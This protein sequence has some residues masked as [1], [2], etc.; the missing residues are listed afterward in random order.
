[1]ALSTLIF[2]VVHPGVSGFPF[3]QFAGGVL[4]AMAYEKGKSLIV[5]ITVHVLGN[6]AIFIL[7]LLF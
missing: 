1:M 3:P 4:F 6:T 5:P 2:V 7:S